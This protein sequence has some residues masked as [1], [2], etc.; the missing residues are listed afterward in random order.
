MGRTRKRHLRRARKRSNAYFHN[1]SA[2]HKNRTSI[3]KKARK[4]AQKGPPRGPQKHALEF[5]W[6]GPF[7]IRV[8]ILS[9]FSPSKN[10]FSE[11][12]AGRKTAK[13]CFPKKAIL[14]APRTLQ[15]GLAQTTRITVFFAFFDFKSAPEEGPKSENSNGRGALGASRESDFGKGLSESGSPCRIASANSY[16]DIYIYI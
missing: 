9:T 2:F 5:R 1:V 16:I 7:Y 10:R 3:Q 6:G 4:G 13:T 8:R 11:I 12:R 15:M 14:G